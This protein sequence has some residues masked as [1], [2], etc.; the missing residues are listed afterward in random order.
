MITY[1]DA[2]HERMAAAAKADAADPTIDSRLD[3][4][5][6]TLLTKYNKLG[7]PHA[8]ARGILVNVCGMLDEEAEHH[9][10]NELI[11]RRRRG[12]RK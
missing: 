10:E 1:D 4:Y 11:I 6:N 5:L 3:F 8:N 9:I 2:W 7:A 12:E